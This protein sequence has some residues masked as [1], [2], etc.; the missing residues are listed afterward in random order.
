MGPFLY[1][2]FCIF[3]FCIITVMNEIDVR[4]AADIRTWFVP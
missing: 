2:A 1:F 4:L 3:V